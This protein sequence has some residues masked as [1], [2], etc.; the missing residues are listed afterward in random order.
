MLIKPPH[1][2]QSQLELYFYPEITSRQKDYRSQLRDRLA[3]RLSQLNES[4]L[5]KSI[6]DL[7]QL[8]NH[9]GYQMSLSHSPLASGFAL[10]KEDKIRVGF[11][12][13][14]IDRI[15]EPVIRRLSSKSETQQAID[16]KHIFPAKEAA[17]KALNKPF[18]LPHLTAVNTKAWEAIEPNWYKFQ[19][20]ISE[21]LVDGLGGLYVNSDTYIC[22]FISSSTFVLNDRKKK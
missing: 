4:P 11:D 12:I 22:F 10:I 8:P 14:S 13:E 1:Y 19:I 20:E 18:Q 3:N 15:T 17:W 6:Q 9:P 5:H 21:E 7:T 16:W 2:F